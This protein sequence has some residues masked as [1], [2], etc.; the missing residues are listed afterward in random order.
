MKTPPLILIADDYPD[1]V[2]LL[3]QRLEQAGYR[4]TTAADGAQALRQVEALRPDLLLLDI[5]M[6]GMGGIEVI[7]ALRGCQEYQDLPII[8]LSARI[9]VEDRVAGLDA[10]ADEYLPKPI[11]EAE[12]LARCGPCSACRRPC[13]PAS[14]W[15]RRTSGCARRS[16]PA[17]A[18]ARW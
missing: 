18:S 2:E 8:V 11:E 16:P 12:L 10:G 5:V 4:T 6:P 3:E 14:A 7:A 9:E 1:N 17:R 15:R 13:A